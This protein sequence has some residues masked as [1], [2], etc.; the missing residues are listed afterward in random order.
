MEKKLPKII[1]IAGP[2]AS[3]KTD[4]GL[5]L[6]KKFDGEI[7]SA[8]SRQVYKKMDIGTAKPKGEWKKDVYM[9][10]GISHYGMDIIEPNQE[11]TLA[12]FKA[13]ATKCIQDIIGRKKIPIIVG[14]T[15]LY[16]WS[17][18]DNLDIPSV[19]P[20]IEL[21]NDLAKK[22]LPELVAMLEKLDPETCAKI[23]LHNPR[24]VLRALEVV[25]SSGQSFF[26]QRTKSEPL[27]EALQ[28]GIEVSK[29]E[30][31]K[32]IDARVD[33]QMVDGLLSE[34]EALVQF[35]YGWDLPSMSGIGYKQMGYY[36]KGEM[37]LQEAEEK[38]KSDTKKFAKRQMTW[39]KRDKR[40][41]WVNVRNLSL[42]VDSVKDFLSV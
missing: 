13:L 23:D 22:S 14:G 36:I 39:F 37:N 8:D 31:Y 29:E 18:V 11:F 16:I 42:A 5:M 10:E 9:V 3:G 38:L 27:F 41:I 2:T 32:R 35:G 40:I 6:A 19:S 20:N 4:L 1:V 33:K 17:V 26:A 15:G 34:T 25:I 30:L 21:R 7:I 28:I 12:D 24:R